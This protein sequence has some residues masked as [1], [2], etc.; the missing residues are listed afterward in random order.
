MIFLW[1]IH[2]STIDYLSTYLTAYLLSIYLP[3]CHPYI[4]TST[5]YLLYLPIHLFMY[6]L[7]IYLA[8]IYLSSLYP[9]LCHLLSYTY[10][11]IYPYVHISTINLP[12]LYLSAY[13]QS[14]TIYL[15]NLS[16]YHLYICRLIIYLFSVYV[17]F[18]L[19]VLPDPWDPL[20]CLLHYKLL[21]IL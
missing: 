9:S 6:L 21:S 4:Y 1:T 19:Y 11:S 8:S 20:S 2:V 5:T 15:S 18:H 16:T 13:Y 14:A 17:M 10:L 12:I 7:S 3:I